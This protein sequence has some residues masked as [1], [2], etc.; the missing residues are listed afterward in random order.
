M[1]R[2]ARLVVVPAW[3]TTSSAGG[4]DAGG[5]WLMSRAARRSWRDW[6]TSSRPPG[7]RDPVR[8]P[9]RRHSAATRGV[10]LVDCRSGHARQAA[11][12][13]PIQ[14][15]IPIRTGGGLFRQ[16]A[17]RGRGA[18]TRSAWGVEQN[19]ARSPMG[20]AGRGRPPS[21]RRLCQRWIMV[22]FTTLDQT[23][24]SS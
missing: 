20:K 4:W 16:V 17:W 11:S 23:A 8:A 5:L 10:R 7:R 18:I 1:P 24:A 3:G 14:Q 9:P 19:Q 22:N 15:R 6:A 12:L 2:R 13:P 21:R